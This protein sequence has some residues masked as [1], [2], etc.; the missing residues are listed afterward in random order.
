MASRVNHIWNTNWHLMTPV[1]ILILLFLYILIPGNVENNL[2]PL[3]IEKLVGEKERLENKLGNLQNLDQN[4]YC[5]GGQLV[6]PTGQENSFLP[7]ETK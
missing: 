6:V 1:V 5:S 3:E 2:S 7:P 4:S